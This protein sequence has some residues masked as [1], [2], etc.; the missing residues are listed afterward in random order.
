MLKIACFALSFAMKWQP[1]NH[2]TQSL[3]GALMLLKQSNKVINTIT[4]N[5]EPK[6]QNKLSFKSFIPVLSFITLLIFASVVI[7]NFHN[8]SN[9]ILS[10]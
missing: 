5:E 6:M 4:Q 7:E 1:T 10:Y 2:T 8:W 3:K 9:Y